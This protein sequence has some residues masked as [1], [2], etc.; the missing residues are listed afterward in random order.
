MDLEKEVARL[1]S[2]LAT[3]QAKLIARKK[4]VDPVPEIRVVQ[5]M[6]RGEVSPLEILWWQDRF[7]SPSWE[8]IVP[9]RV[10]VQQFVEFCDRRGVCAVSNADRMERFL[11]LV[12]PYGALKVISRGMEVCRELTYRI[13]SRKDCMAYYYG[14]DG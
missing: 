8:P 2:E 10:L 1:Q 3:I 9:S 13:G 12:A 14:W 4:M 11:S 7:R 5:M 6:T